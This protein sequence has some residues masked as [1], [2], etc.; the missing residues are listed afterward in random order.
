MSFEVRFALTAIVL[1]GTA[2]FLK[3]RYRHEVIPVHS[4]LSS[5]P[6]Q[7]GGWRGTDEP[8]SSDILETLG[9][10]DFLSR[11]YR[12]DSARA[13]Y[14]N[15]FMAY[16]PSQSTG[17]TIHSPQNCLPGSGWFSLEVSQI[18]LTVP[19]HAPF[20]V[21]RYYVAQGEDRA[22]VLYWYWAHNR[23]VASEY[24]AK[25]YLI[26]DAISLNR[27]DGALIRLIEYVRPGE[28]TESVQQSLL[29]FSGELVPLIDK[30]V[31]N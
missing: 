28:T 8:I 7:L 31:P 4:P 1:A 13:S 21:N 14:I 11:T 20:R 12:N 2:L 19:G 6:K 26:A 3:A 18:R 27:T 10:G 29:A 23:G 9:S 25:F 15:L 17:D 24:W 5:M 30:Y 16:F 22:L